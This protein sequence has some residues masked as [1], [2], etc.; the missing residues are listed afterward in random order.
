MC[1]AVVP[2]LPLIGAGIGAAAT[3]YSVHEQKKDAAAAR[4]QTER[5]MQYAREQAT[6]AASPS[7]NEQSQVAA[8]AAAQKRAAAAQGLGSTITGAGTSYTS[9]GL[10]YGTKSKLGM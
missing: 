2:F 4:E 7:L 6:Q 3:A 10:G 1:A 8:R 5:Q 9:S